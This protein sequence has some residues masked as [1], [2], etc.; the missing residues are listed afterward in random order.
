MFSNCTGAG[1]LYI[2]CMSAA[3]SDPERELPRKAGAPKGNRNAWKH[4]RRSAAAKAARAADRAD[5]V[6]FLPDPHL[7]FTSLAYADAVYAQVHEGSSPAKKGEN[8]TGSQ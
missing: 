2:L 3:D 7:V 5:I 1:V 4:G 8:S 6:A